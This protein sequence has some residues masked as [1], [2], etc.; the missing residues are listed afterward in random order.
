M[1]YYEHHIGDYIKATAHLSMLED[2]AYRR[3]I[4]AYYTRELPLPVEKK[5]CHRL[6]RA[7][8][9]QEK[10]A[11]DTVLE[12]FFSLDHDGWHQKRCDSEIEKYFE[13]LPAADEKKEND[14]ER[15]K[16]ARERRKALFEA[17]SERG[18]NMPWNSTTEQLQAELSR[19]ETD[20]SHEPVT[21]PVTRDNT[22]TH[23]PYT[24]HQYVNPT[25]VERVD[26]STSVAR[27]QIS[28]GDISPSAEVCIGLKRM[29]YSDTNPHDFEL[30][31]LLQAGMTPG[32]I[33][34]VGQEFQGHGKRFRYLL[35]TAE[36]RRRDAANVQP[37]PNATAPPRSKSIHDQ[38]AETIAALTGRNRTNERTATE[39]RDITAE[40]VRI[41]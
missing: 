31:A 25:V 13:K 9:K 23:T 10:E 14:R 2:A 4:D 8:S 28:P 3:L 37:L 22:A 18:V 12:E 19:I 17:L 24:R 27:A 39:P 40:S 35:K 29:G 11:V 32:E 7:F 38:R 26:N 36:G 41:A 34:A 5:A 20:A 6:A 21:Q 16:R 15:Q 33:L 1:N 30:S